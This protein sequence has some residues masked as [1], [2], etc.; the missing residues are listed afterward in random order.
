MSILLG[1]PR[2]FGVA[3]LI[4][5]VLLVACNSGG[6]SGGVQQCVQACQT[7]LATNCE[8]RALD[9]CKNAE[10]NCEARYSAHPDCHAQLEAMDQCAVAQPASNF[11]CPLGTLPNEIRPYHL[12]DDVCVEVGMALEGCF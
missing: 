11:T 12:T 3:T 1:S 5:C 9:F 6:G 8:T 4:A 2:Y 10:Q 7:L